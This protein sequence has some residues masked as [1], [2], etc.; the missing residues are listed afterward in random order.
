MRTLAPRGEASIAFATKFATTR[1]VRLATRPLTTAS[2][3]VAP[4]SR[5]PAWS[6]VA[7]ARVRAASTTSLIGTG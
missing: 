1:P 5:M 4:E 2:L 6:A 3:S 7:A